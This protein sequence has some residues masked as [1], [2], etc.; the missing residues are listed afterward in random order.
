MNLIN[1]KLIVP[2][3]FSFI[4]VSLTESDVIMHGQIDDFKIYIFALPE[5]CHTK[6]LN[7]YLSNILIK[8]RD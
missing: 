8:S 1:D 6:D 7:H 5:K 3:F 2:V 4:R